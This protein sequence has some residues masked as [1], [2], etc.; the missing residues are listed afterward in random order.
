MYVKPVAGRA[1]IDPV[2]GE[3]LPEIGA[4]KPDTEFWRRA[5]DVH[6]DVE[7]TEPPPEPEAVSEVEPPAEEAPAA[8]PARKTKGA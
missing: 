2:T 4:H 7:E 3:L 1:V 5:R 8:V 6:K